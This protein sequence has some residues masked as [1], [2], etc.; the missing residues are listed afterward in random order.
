MN[1]QEILVHINEEIARLEQVKALLNGGAINGAAPKTG[2]RILSAEA[3]KKIAAAQRRRWAKVR[4][5]AV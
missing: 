3:R 4:K 1:T 2:K 5:A